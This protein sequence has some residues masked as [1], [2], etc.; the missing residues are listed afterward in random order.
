MR[1][2]TLSLIFF[3]L[4]TIVGLGWTL[5]RLFNLYSS[6]SST[7]PLVVYQEMG[8]QLSTLLDQQSLPERLIEQWPE[9]QS[10]SLDYMNEEALPVPENLLTEFREGKPLT[11]ESDTDVSIYYY[12]PS[13]GGVL[14]LTPL[15]LQPARNTRLKFLLTGLFYLGVGSLL[16]VW[17]Y[18]L[19]KRLIALRKSAVEFGKGH[20]QERIPVGRFSYITDIETEFNRMADR[21]QILIADNKLLSSAVSHDLRT[22]LA[23]LRFGI[24]TL[25]ETPDI[26]SQEVYIKRLSNDVDE[27]EKLVN[28]LLAFARLDNVMAA[29]QTSK[30]NLTQLVSECVSLH[31]ETDKTL[32]ISGLQSATLQGNADFLAM[33][34]NNLLTNAINHAD[35]AVRIALTSDKHRVTLEVADDGPGVPEQSRQTIMQPFH[36]GEN[37]AEGQARSHGQTRGHG[38][39]LAIVTRVAQWHGATVTV[40]DCEKLQGALFTVSFPIDQR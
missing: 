26:A 8:Q 22:P 2:L 24:D 11:L 21:I 31:V 10:V 27:M 4:C 20:L 7:E 30:I 19:I 18:P 3:T 40:G 9:R 38:L 6:E 15:A 13:H 35:K 29:A 36:R 37:H 23:R 1:A 12:L 32:D 14:S 25:G 34:T 28:S 17:L 5:D 16:L 39:G 33:L